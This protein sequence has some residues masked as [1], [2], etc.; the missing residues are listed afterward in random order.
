MNILEIYI[1]GVLVSLIIHI[2][3]CVFNDQLVALM[4]PFCEKM[5]FEKT[6]N[7]HLLTWRDHWNNMK[8]QVLTSWIGVICTIV[9]FFSAIMYS[10]YINSKN[11]SN[12]GEK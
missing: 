11:Q 12:E 9:F 2:L 8:L 6:P 5:E 1:V 7:T 3:S 4:T 10:M